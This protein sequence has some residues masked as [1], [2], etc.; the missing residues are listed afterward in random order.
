VAGLGAGGAA[1]GGGPL[2]GLGALVAGNGLLAIATGLIVGII[3]SGTL[4]ATGAVHVGGGTAAPIPTPVG[5]QLVACP[6]AG[7][8]IGS[9]PKGEKVL[10]TARSADGAWLQVY[11][12]GPAF[13]RAWT[14]AGPLQLEADPGS[15]PVASCEAPPTPTPRPTPGASTAVAASPEASPSVEPSASAAASPSSSPTTG[16]SPSP[17]VSP[18]PTPSP[19]PN[20]PPVIAGFT[21]STT[22]LSYDEGAYCPTATQ[23][24]TFT[25][26]AS[27]AGGVAS[28]TLY[29]RKPGESAYRPLPMQL[30]GGSA[31]SGTWTA[32]VDT[33]TNG[34]WNAGNFAAYAVALDSS[35]AST[36]SPKSGALPIPVSLCV[37]TGPTFTSGPT[38]GNSTLYADPLN[39]GCGSPIGTEISATITDVDGV[40]SATLVFT[41]QAG[42][43]VN[44]PMA[45]VPGNLWTSFINA[46]DDGTHGPGNFTWHVIATDTKG[47][48]TTSDTQP[49]NVKRCDTPASFDF[50]SVTTPVYNAAPCTPTSVTIP[51]FASDPDNGSGDSS[52]LQVVLNWQATN[53]RSGKAFSGQVQAVF[54]K[55]NAFIASFPVTIDWQ[56]TLYTL[57]YFA[58]STDVYGG[59]SKSFT[60]K[61]QISVYAC[62]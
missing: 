56:A 43:T 40:A 8:V 61:T 58:T 17:G 28:A 1:G 13:D 26:T 48:S 23:S 60:G 45:G 62:Q 31:Q 9:I 22:S 18:S 6:D 27:D 37:N 55:G 20:L 51:A 33:K 5:L 24:V 41:D 50:G 52:R 35:G 29:W 3:G 2:A 10:V 12:P 54:Q 21:A 49:I 47:L 42:R 53:L 14:K 39:A 32:T 30:S 46:N 36:K 15:L 38:A 16:P 4:L 57:T 25:L 7:P 59:T 11:Y 19:T 34:P 44:R